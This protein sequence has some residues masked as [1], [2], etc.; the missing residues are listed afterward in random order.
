MPQRD[1]PLWLP[2][3]VMEKNPDAGRHPRATQIGSDAD[4]AAAPDPV[5]ETFPLHG[6]QVSVV[7]LKQIH[8][9][10]AKHVKAPAAFPR[11]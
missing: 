11:T 7:R 1:V 5:G 4:R 3:T 2:L 8:T 9:R 10:R 6:G